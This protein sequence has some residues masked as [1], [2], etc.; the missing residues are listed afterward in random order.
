M[1]T[2]I[3]V[4]QED[5]DNGRRKD[6]CA[7]PIALA[8]NRNLATGLYGASVGSSNLSEEM[9]AYIFYDSVTISR[10]SLPVDAESFVVDF[11]ANGPSG[12]S[13]FTF[14]LLD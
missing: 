2:I 12:V 1:L 4:T 6:A 5:I 3:E 9:T 11:D 10:Y 7:C 14:A 13:P 8:I